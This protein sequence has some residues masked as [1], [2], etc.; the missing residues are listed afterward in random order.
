[1]LRLSSAFTTIGIVIW[2]IASSVALAANADSQGPLRSMSVTVPNDARDE[3]FAQ[4]RDYADQYGWA[5]RIA[6]TR[7]G[8]DYFLVAM[9]REGLK[10]LGTTNSIRTNGYTF[11][12]YFHPNSIRPAPTSLLDGLVEGLRAALRRVPGASVSDIRNRATEGEL[13]PPAAV[14]PDF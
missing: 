11:N 14:T 8:N 10:I 4:F 1:M 6:P 5:I 12:L 9:Y 3:L 7:P 2:A 13:K